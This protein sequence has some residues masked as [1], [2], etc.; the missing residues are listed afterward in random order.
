MVSLCSYPFL[1]L[2]RVVQRHLTGHFAPGDSKSNPHKDIEETRCL[3]DV[4]PSEGGSP[5]IR[6]MRAAAASFRAPDARSADLTIPFRFSPE[7]D[8][9]IGTAFV[10]TLVPYIGQ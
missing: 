8:V 2:L 10:S 7:R 1:K 3:P 9:G 6:N 4:V 5:Q